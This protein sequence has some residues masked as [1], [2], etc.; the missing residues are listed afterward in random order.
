MQKQDRDIKL[1]LSA[2]QIGG[3][4]ETAFNQWLKGKCAYANV[5]E[6]LRMF[7][8]RH[9]VNLPFNTLPECRYSLEFL[10]VHFP[11]RGSVGNNQFWKVICCLLHE[12]GG[13]GVDEPDRLL[14][15]LNEQR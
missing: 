3:I 2:P 8:K 14:V 13:R 6:L 12:A 9:G 10:S 7:E 11:D 15:Y 1:S 5:Y 4:L